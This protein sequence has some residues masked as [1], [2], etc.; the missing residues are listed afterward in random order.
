MLIE[1]EIDPDEGYV[2]LCLDAQTAADRTFL[3][4]VHE[5]LRGKGRIEMFDADGK[6]LGVESEAAK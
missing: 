3:Q 5:C 2:A 1:T 6:L 4:L